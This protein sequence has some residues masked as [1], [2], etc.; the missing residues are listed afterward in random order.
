MSIFFTFWGL[1]PLVRPDVRV[2]GKNWMQK[3]LAVMNRQIDFFFSDP[4]AMP[5]VKGG[6]LRALAVSTTTRSRNLP[7]VPTSPL[8][9]ASAPHP[10][11]TV[12]M[13]GHFDTYLLGYRDR[14]RA[15]PPEH[16]PLVQTG[17]GFLTPHVVVD[18]RVVAVW[19]RDGARFTV[20]PFMSITS[21]AGVSSV[22]STVNPFHAL[23]GS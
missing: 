17:G 7:D 12:R 8:Q 11:G 4:S 16:A 3:M 1:F 21:T 22:D 6:K 10:T 13:L 9:P 15:L 18:G 19:R 14:S 2:T 5:H 23:S 20:R